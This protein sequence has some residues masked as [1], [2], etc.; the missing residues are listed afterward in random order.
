MKSII[1]IGGGIQQVPAVARLKDIG[2]RVIVT[3]TNREAPAFTQADVCVN[4]GALD[5]KSLI[6][7][8][9]INKTNL[10]IAGIFTLTNYAVSVALVANATGLP[11]LPPEIAV[12]CDNKLLM[13]RKFKEFGFLTPEYYEVSSLQETLNAFATLG[14]T[15]YLKVVDGFGG[16]GVSKITSKD[17]I[18][19]VYSAL[20]NESLY[21]EMIL[22]KEIIG[23]FIDT[24]GVFHEGTFY[25][26]GDADSFFSNNEE[27]YK[28]FNPVET[29]NICPSQRSTA[30][31]ET[32][33]NMLR[34][35]AIA[36]KMDF[37]PV[38]GDFV[39]DEQG[40]HVIEVGPRLHG[41]NG[42]LQ[43]F[44]KA[45]QIKPLEFMAQVLCGDTPNSEFVNI[46]RES[47]AL[48]HV[49]VSDKP[50]IEDV[51]F[52]ESPL[53]QPGVFT[54]YVYKKA[55]KTLKQS[56]MKLSGLASV[57]V[58]GDNLEQAQS[59]LETVKSLFYVE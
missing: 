11:T 32:A 16:K 7:W 30:D 14:G 3:D 19:R 26:A 8:I 29:F 28:N 6:S 58:S 13:K 57:F 24:Q 43:M 46:S 53:I 20:K 18:H 2:Y 12:T 33:Y 9:L 49:F 59:R 35:I 51:G 31:I 17:D 27:Q 5:V 47:I 4:I 25:P 23:H 55:G 34:D 44:P 15:C 10:N 42:T 52:T 22:E 37:G 54:S 41:P 40:L 38:G 45:M 21:P 48:C 39:L 36:L 50:E 56:A 1:M